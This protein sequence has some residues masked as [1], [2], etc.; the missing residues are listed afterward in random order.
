LTD[1]RTTRDKHI[2]FNSKTLL[3]ENSRRTALFTKFMEMAVNP[4]RVAEKT[5]M[6]S[7]PLTIARGFLC[8]CMEARVIVPS[9]C[10][11]EPL[12]D[13]HVDVRLI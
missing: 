9:S 11:H 1:G 5:C 7:L 12:Q 3:R 4:Y 8:A 6:A 13:G 2:W 10:S